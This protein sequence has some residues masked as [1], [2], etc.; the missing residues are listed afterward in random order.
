MFVYKKSLNCYYRSWQMWWH[1]PRY[2][3]LPSTCKGGSRGGAT[4]PLP[5]PCDCTLW[6]TTERLHAQVTNHVESW[7][8]QPQKKLKGAPFWTFSGRN[9]AVVVLHILLHIHWN[10]SINLDDAVDR[11]ARK[12]PRKLVSINYKLFC[13]CTCYLLAYSIDT[14]FWMIK[15]SEHLPIHLVTLLTWKSQN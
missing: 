14:C 3:A 12:H 4:A 15:N 11:L 1:V 10:I 5:S 9:L 13:Y 7:V 2:Q 8:L 6:H